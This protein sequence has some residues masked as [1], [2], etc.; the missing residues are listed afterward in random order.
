MNEIVLENQHTR[1]TVDPR[2]GACAKSFTC[3]IDEQWV[4]VFRDANH[5]DMVNDSACFPLAPFASRVQDGVFSW[6]GRDV[7]LAPNFLPQRHAL[8]GHSWQAPWL[9]VNQSADKLCLSFDY[10]NGD[11]PWDYSIELMYQ[12]IGSTLTMSLR[13]K[14]LSSSEM[15]SGLGFHPFFDI[16]DNTSIKVDASTMWQVDETVLPTTITDSPRGINRGSGVMAHELLIDNVLI[17]DST[18]RE[19][20]WADRGLKANIES[21]G[22]PYTVLYR[23]PNAN[24]LCVEPISHCTNALNLEEA[25]AI[26]AGVKPL[27]PHEK[28][29]VTMSIALQ[30]I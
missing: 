11:W 7:Q 6:Q 13:L 17:N 1:L 22:C 20:V 29:Q 8:H 19:I 3:K 25:A 16:D 23:P 30:A 14:N 24:F 18:S 26:A 27:A 12:L 4:D 21:T 2:L 15:P 5:A 28:H 9:V 10:K